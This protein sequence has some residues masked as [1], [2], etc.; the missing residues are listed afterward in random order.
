MQRTTF[1]ERRRM[2]PLAVRWGWL[3]AHR[4]CFDLPIGPGERGVANLVPCAAD[5]VC[6]VLY[7]L[8]PEECD[9]LDTTEG[10]GGGFYRRIAV[11]VATA[12]GERIEA[13]AY[14]SP[15]STPGRKPSARYIG[16]LL[17]GASEQGLPEEWLRLLGRSSSR[18][19]SARA[20]AGDDGA[21]RARSRRAS[22]PLRS[23]TRQA[24]Q[25]QLL[26]TRD[27]RA[28]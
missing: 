27:G 2:R 6:G 20:R 18:S 15:F 11:D 3:H 12:D 13:F 24:K 16:L 19:T 1:L 8:T 14:H 7:L 10:V 22:P 23:L 28:R 4:L 5:R 25:L 26:A 21:D 17:E 9:R